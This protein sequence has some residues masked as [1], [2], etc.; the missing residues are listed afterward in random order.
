MMWSASGGIEVARTPWHQVVVVAHA[1]REE[2]EKEEEEEEEKR[3]RTSNIQEPLG[4]S[5][6]AGR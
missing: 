4:P 5:S 6:A 3:R 2:A 1:L